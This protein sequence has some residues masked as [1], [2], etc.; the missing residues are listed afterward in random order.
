MSAAEFC[1]WCGA[2]PLRDE[3][4][5]VMAWAVTLEME[6]DCDHELLSQGVEW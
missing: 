6:P 5:E 3:E 4:G 2:Q 1:I